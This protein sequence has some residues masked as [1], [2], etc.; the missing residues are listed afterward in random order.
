M[1]T[2]I[3]QDILESYIHCRY[4]AYLKLKGQS[5]I[6]S[7][8]ENFRL[9]LRS[10]V[11]LKAFSKIYA[12]TSDKK[13][14][15][16]VVL[17]DS[18]FNKEPLFILNTS[19]KV[20]HLT[21]VIDGIKRITTKRQDL[22]FYAPMMI[23][24]G[25]RIR[26]E[27]R[28]LLELC[29]AFL[30]KCQSIVPTVG[31]IWYSKDCKLSTIRLNI[32]SQKVKQIQLDLEK[33]SASEMSPELILNN[34]CQICEFQAQC[35]ENA[36][37]ED[38]LSLIRGISVKEIK[39][40]NRRGILTITQLAHT[41]R[42]RRKR[43][44]AAKE[45]KSRYHALQALA[46]RD[47][48]IYILGTAQIPESLVHIYLDIESNPDTDFV[49]LIG[50]V[51]VESG[52]EEHHS[53]WADSKEQQV[54]I[55]E[56]FVNEVTKR[57]KFVIFCYGGY[58]RAFITKMRKTSPDKALVDRILNALVNMLSIIYTHFYF[59]TY[60]NGL[61]DIGRYVGYNW[62]EPNASGLQSIVWRINWESNNDESWKH[63][64]LTYNIEDCLALKKVTETL[65]RFLSTT[66]VEKNPNEDESS[67][68]AVGFVEDIEKLSD[69]HTW[70]AVDFVQ[71]EFEFINKR[72]YFDYQRER[73]YIRSSKAIRK[74]KTSKPPS[75]NRS[76][77]ASKKITIIASQCPVCKNE[78]VISGVK[79]QVRTQ[80]PRV[81]RT[82]D[83]VF[84]PSGVRRRVI[85]CRTSVHKCLNCNEEFVPIEHQKLDKH[86]H[87]LKSWVIFQHVKYRINLQMLSKM[88]ED[89]FG[90][91]VSPSEVH[92]L[93]ILMARYYETTYNLLL[94]N[95]IAGKLVHV[96]ET[97]VKLQKGKGYVWV[98]T[99]LEEVYY[100]YRPSRE[101]SFLHEL[102][103]DFNGVLV[104]DFYSAYDSLEC[105]QQKCLVHL[106]RDMN[107]ELLNNPFDNELKKITQ[108]FGILLREIVTT[109]DEYGL[110]KKYLTRH[111]QKVERFF[112]S[113]DNLVTS[114]DAAETLRSRLIKNRDKLFTFIKH[115][116]V[117]WNNN[118]AEQAIKQF[119]YYREIN[120]GII[121]ESGLQNYLILLSIY[122]T[123]RY[124][125]ADFLKFLLS[126]EQDID[127]FTKR[128]Q[129]RHP[130]LDIELYPEGFVP[131]HL[132]SKR[133]KKR[134]VDDENK[135]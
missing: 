88:I 25:S 131:Q 98:F 64:I 45:T 24:E 18:V 73:V 19:I 16:D 72:A 119:A 118:N 29:A 130:L 110:K 112:H 107:Q 65:R 3:T 97:P 113:I 20:G 38:N 121:F 105:P 57:E 51:I 27:Q 35:Y 117:P 80:E 10:E 93:K 82:F 94:E 42:P 126:K 74:A 99:N 13:V 58:E 78:N 54:E 125:G 40:F 8:Y 71:P 90:I 53:F 87:G 39:S 6:K 44:N 91:R 67:S 55:F 33:I 69:Y 4:K 70:R 127:V 101:G 86:F 59:P 96:D 68:L 114:S 50:L 135:K 124:K 22:F 123:C 32:D 47:E 134:Q 49:Y 15:S 21:I 128:S 108:P 111:S 81:K 66:N 52:S 84:T 83:V 37:Q 1:E 100:F 85:E 28:L 14:M 89:F 11:R 56:Q 95:I 76:L 104:S 92:M 133:N 132:A 79:K 26:K 43:K 122:Q 120:N 63:K 17:T 116:G 48:K 12:Q 9:K 31:V 30:L 103:S 5:G 75:P 2:R 7:D 41:F 34:H 36:R 23:Y 62:T 102:L 129:Q 106:I 109:I 46:I 61:K 60:S 77:P 115:D